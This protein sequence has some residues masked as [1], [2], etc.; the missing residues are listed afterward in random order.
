MCG[1]CGLI[2]EQTDWTDLPSELPRRQER[3]K[4]LSVINKITKP[5]HVTVSDVQGVNFLVQTL[6]GKAALANGLDALWGQIEQLTG[7]P[8]DVLDDDYLKRLSHFNL[9][10]FD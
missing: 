5:V 2:E 8:I 6:T 10:H 1:L 9:S 3:Q 7:K 4:R